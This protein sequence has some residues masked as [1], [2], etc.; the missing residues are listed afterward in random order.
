MKKILSSLAVALACLS[1][2]PAMAT[3]WLDSSYYAGDRMTV[4]VYLNDW[5]P[6]TLWGPRTTWRWFYGAKKQCRQSLNHM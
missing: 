2:T 3:Y 5:A 1:A 6:N 4:C